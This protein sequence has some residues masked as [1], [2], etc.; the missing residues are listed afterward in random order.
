MNMKGSG[1]LKKYY[2]PTQLIMGEKTADKI[3]S[4]IGNSHNHVLLVSTDDQVLMPL[5]DQVKKSLKEAGLKLTH[6]DGVKPNPTVS[7][8]ED[9]LLLVEGKD[10][11]AILAVGGGSSMDSAK[12][13][14][15]KHALSET[16][17]DHLFEAYDSPWLESEGLNDVLPIYALPTTSGTGSQVT[18]AAVLSQGKDKLTLFHN[19]LFV[20]VAILDPNLT[21]TLPKRLTSATAFDAFTHAFES[22]ISER[23]SVLSK[24]DSLKAMSLIIEYLPKVLKEP[25]NLEYRFQLMMADTLGGRALSNAGAHIPHPLSEIIGGISNG[26]HGELLAA[27]YPSFI[28]HQT[29]KFKEE[30]QTIARLFDQSADE[31]DL[32]H[33]I[34]TFLCDIDCNPSIQDFVNEA[35]WDK[36]YHHPVLKVLPFGDETLL[37]K[38][39]KDAYA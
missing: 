19:D 11:D 6:F 5:Y 9:A 27:V 22:Y 39:L 20:K 13:I 21:K 31:N 10:I 16:S 7:S 17:W 1:A 35:E 3:G 14:A 2:Q 23:A 26:M 30:F 25:D 29:D 33:L 36:I 32:Y 34:K 12:A 8:I 15:L 4:L 24:H 18:Q 28:K 37:Q 38:I